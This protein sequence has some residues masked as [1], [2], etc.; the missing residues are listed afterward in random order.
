MSSDVCCFWKVGVEGNK[1]RVS[2]TK[3]NC[4]LPLAEGFENSPAF[5]DEQG[6]FAL[7]NIEDG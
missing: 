5:V 4:R 3:L 7:Q 1:A 2:I 6:V